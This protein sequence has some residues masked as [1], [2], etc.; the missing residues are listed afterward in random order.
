M[1][2]QALKITTQSCISYDVAGRGMFESAWGNSV[3]EGNRHFS[4]LAETP[5]IKGTH[6]RERVTDRIFDH[7]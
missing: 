1:D 7:A 5:L 4:R 6:G 2:Y 3:S